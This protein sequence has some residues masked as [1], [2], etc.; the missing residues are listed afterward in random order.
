SVAGVMVLRALNNRVEVVKVERPR[1]VAWLAQNWTEGQ[2][3]RYYHTA[4]GSELIPYA[5]F[6]AL[7]Q[8]RFTIKGAGPFRENSYLEG[9]GFIPDEISLE[10]PYGLPARFTSD[11]RFVDPYAGQ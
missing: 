11:D 1:E 3:R 10:N 5:W 2:R 8:P 9:F 7:E 4:Q 6:L